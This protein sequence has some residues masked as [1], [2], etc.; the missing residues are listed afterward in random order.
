MQ[1]TCS[2]CKKPVTQS[3]TLA[4][5]KQYWHCDFCLFTGLDEKFFISRDDEK[6]R[7]DL[8][9]NSIEDKGYVEFLEKFINYAIT[10][11]QDSV[12]TILDYGSGPKPVL[13]ELLKRK[14]YQVSVYDPLYAPKEFHNESFDLICST[15]V[16]EHFYNPMLEIAKIV[17]LLKPGGRL[18]VMTRFMPAVDE[19]RAWFYK[20][21]KTHVSFYSLETFEYIA[22]EFGL[23]LIKDDGF[24]CL[25]LQKT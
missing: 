14:S 12:K 24:Q 16:F 9:E 20:D 6:S 23:K 10:P 18:S 25:V 3:T 19:F 5:S 15:E 8:H 13:A 1:V 2:I 4:N 21:D 17:K 22:K 7:Y 11:Y